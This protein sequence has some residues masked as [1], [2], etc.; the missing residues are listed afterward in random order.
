MDHNHQN[1]KRQSKLE[2]F[3]FIVDNDLEDERHMSFWQ[4][5]GGHAMEYSPWL[6]PIGTKIFAIRDNEKRKAAWVLSSVVLGE[7]KNDQVG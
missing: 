6:R 1:F 4:P 2:W 5:S 3:P 7:K